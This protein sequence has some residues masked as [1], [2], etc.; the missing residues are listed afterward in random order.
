[1]T[2]ME[3]EAPPSAECVRRLARVHAGSALSSHARVR[4]QMNVQ[5]CAHAHRFT[6][7]GLRGS[8]LMPARSKK[9]CATVRPRRR[10][11]P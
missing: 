7:L 3:A 9:A 10:W 2:G 1:M 8:E 5:A 11:F 4:A 6:L